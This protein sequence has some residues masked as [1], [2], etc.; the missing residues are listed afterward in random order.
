M[1]AEWRALNGWQPGRPAKPDPGGIFR[2]ERHGPSHLSPLRPYAPLIFWFSLASGAHP[3]DFPDFFGYP[4]PPIWE[5]FIQAPRRR[6]CFYWASFLR[7]VASPNGS[8]RAA[9]LR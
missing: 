9:S 2:N 7:Q 4:V 1:E 3:P 5:F 8:S 6:H